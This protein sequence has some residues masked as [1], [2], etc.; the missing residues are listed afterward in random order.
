MRIQQLLNEAPLGDYQTFGDFG[1]NSSFRHETDREM[2]QN[3]KVIEKVRQK[4]KNTSGTFNL[5]FVNSPK[6]NRHTEVGL[7][8]N[9]WVRKELGD[10]VADAVDRSSSE[11]INIIFTNNKGEQRVPMT[12]W[13]MAHRIAHAFGRYDISVNGA[14]PQNPYLRMA[15]VAL[16]NHCGSLLSDVYGRREIPKHLNKVQTDRNAQ[17]LYKALFHEIGTFR[18]ARNRK[19]RDWFEMI[20]ELFAQYLTTGRIKLKA[21]PIMLGRGRYSATRADDEGTRD[22]IDDYLYMIEDEVMAHFESAVHWAEGKTWV[23]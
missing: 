6:A 5:Y 1:R 15:H 4:F 9:D 12:P 20:N 17:L 21:P 19:L 3:S 16:I 7:V 10:E 11:D 22:Q 23:M 18:S 13:I 8:T 2:I 14:K